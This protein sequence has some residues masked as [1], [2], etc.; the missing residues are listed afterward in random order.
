MG[1]RVQPREIEVPADDPFENDLLGR[2]EAVD[3][4]THLVGNLDGPCAITVDA[5]W[6]FGKTTFLENVVAAP[7]Q[8]GISRSRSSMPG[9]PIFPTIR[10]SPSPPS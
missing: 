4:L 6:G 5:A 1:I 7:A 8:P 10:S 2:R 3:T 9:R